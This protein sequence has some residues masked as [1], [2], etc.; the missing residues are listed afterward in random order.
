MKRDRDDTDFREVR[1]SF[2]RRE[3]GCAFCEIPKERILLG[4]ELAFAIYDK[5]PVTPLHA[6]V[7]PKR[8]IDDYFGLSRPE[9]NA[10]N[11]LLAQLRETIQHK[12][13]SVLGFNIG[14]NNGEAAGQTVFHSHIHLIPRR[15]GDVDDPRG[16]I[17]NIFPDKGN[18]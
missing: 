12:D 3:P 6:L 4:N 17:R 8:H 7:I 14:V 2:S 13:N 18:Y 9:I 16:G 5:Y 10:C 1:E 15:E 11:S